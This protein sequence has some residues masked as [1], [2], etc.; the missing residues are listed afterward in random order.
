[1][2]QPSYPVD[3]PP[4]LTATGLSTN[5][6]VVQAFFWDYQPQNGGANELDPPPLGELPVVRGSYTDDAS[7][8]VQHQYS[9]DLA[10][11]P[12]G[13]AVGQWVQ[14]VLGLRGIAPRIYNLPVM[15][16]TE[17]RTDN[18]QQGGASITAADPAAV[19]N[20]LPYERDTTLTGTLRDLVGSVVTANLRRVTD[21]SGVPA[22]AIPAETVAEFGVG[23]WDACLKVADAVGV[24]LWFTDKGDVVGRL[25]SEIP[26]APVTTIERV[27][28]PPGGQ[29]ISE[30][31]PTKALVMLTRGQGVEPLYGEAFASTII[32]GLP[33]WYPALVVTMRHEG[34]A[35]TTQVGADEMAMD[36]LK[37]RL[38]DYELYTDLSILPA[39]WLEAAV[40]TVTMGGEP[41]WVQRVSIDLPSLATTASLRWAVA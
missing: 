7:Q 10:Y 18:T 29:G 6:P 1:M 3:V 39:P 27:L 8:P 38:G 36:L 25:R 35:T 4:S 19:L 14:V 15:L 33:P 16:V 26:P 24:V 17:I 31:Y 21:V 28:V 22:I 9:L 30:R 11:A 37:V 40:D 2:R 32:G 20:G 34:D 12:E 23:S 13:L 41:L 5:V